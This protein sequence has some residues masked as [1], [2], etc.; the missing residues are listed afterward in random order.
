VHRD[1]DRDDRILPDPLAS[2]HYP[3]ATLFVVVTS[4][5]VGGRWLPEQDG[6]LYFK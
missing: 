1:A 3:G 6:R 5:G 4:E 2:I